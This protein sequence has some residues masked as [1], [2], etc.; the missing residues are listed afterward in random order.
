MNTPHL[1]TPLTVDTLWHTNWGFCVRT[2]LAGQTTDFFLDGRIAWSH[3][4][5]AD[6]FIERNRQ[7]HHNVFDRHG[8]P[9][10]L[11]PGVIAH[12]KARIIATGD[13]IPLDPEWAVST[14]QKLWNARIERA[15]PE[16]RPWL[17]EYRDK[18]CAEIQ[19]VLSGHTSSI[20]AID[21]IIGVCSA[22]KKEK[23]V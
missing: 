17:A 8:T 10:L 16:D 15:K 19:K 2:I 14:V 7:E 13:D 5:Y 9:N 6:S 4:D 12:V 3:R 21:G 11:V 1:T 20:A 22:L 23:D 18:L